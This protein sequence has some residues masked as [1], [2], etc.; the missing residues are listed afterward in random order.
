M[1][2][3]LPNPPKGLPGQKNVGD[4]QTPP[5][6]LRLAGLSAQSCDNPPSTTISDPVIKDASLLATKS[7]AFATSLASAK[8]C[9]GTLASMAA[10]AP[11]NS[12]AD[13]P[14]LPWNGVLIGP[15]LTA[16]TRI[17]REASSAASE[18]ARERTAALVAERI[19]RP[20]VPT[21]LRNDVVST[22]L[23]P[24]VKSGTAFWIVKK[25]PLKLTANCS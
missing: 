5:P 19:E 17:P 3:A 6:G 14:S 12:C 9:R 24:F 1:P 15:G 11:F 25:I 16:F 23:A 20:G 22:T 18:R 10:A 13:S 4:T 7:T 21:A 8:R 2:G